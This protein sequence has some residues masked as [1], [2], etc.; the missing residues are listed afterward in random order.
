MRGL[1]EGCYNCCHCVVQDGCVNEDVVEYDRCT[2]DDEN[3]DPSD[4]WCIHYE[5]E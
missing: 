2:F 5:E 1:L 4:G 3:F